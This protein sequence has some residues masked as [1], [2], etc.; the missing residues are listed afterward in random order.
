MVTVIMRHIILAP[1]AA[2]IVFVFV[3]AADK[4]SE[5]TGDPDDW[6][7]VNAVTVPDFAA[8]TDPVILYDRTISKR[9]RAYWTVELQELTAHG[10]VHVCDSGEPQ[11]NDYDPEE[12]LARVRLF[13][14]Y[15]GRA[16]PCDVSPGLNYVVKTIWRGR[17]VPMIS[18]RSNVFTV[19][20][21]DD[22]A[23]P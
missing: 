8:G 7:I 1:V 4:F 6:M 16:S 23:H 22:G 2:F 11:G 3:N 15:M 9:F 13:S 18:N 17:G 5:W 12:A 21:P 14:W 10:A 19:F 20:P